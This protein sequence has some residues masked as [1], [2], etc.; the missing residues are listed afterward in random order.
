MPSISATPYLSGRYG[1]HILHRHLGGGSWGYEIQCSA[2]GAEERTDTCSSITAEDSP[3]VFAAAH[4][5]CATDTPQQT[6]WRWAVTSSPDELH[7]S[8]RDEWAAEI[9]GRVIACNDG[10]LCISIRNGNRERK[11]IITDDALLSARMVPNAA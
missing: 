1:C 10:M 9:H 7:V 3:R 2:C 8:F 11:T 6:A 5:Q 4:Q